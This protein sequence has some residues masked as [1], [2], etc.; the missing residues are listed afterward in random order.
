VADDR[1]ALG[2]RGEDMAVRHLVEAGYVILERNYRCSQGEMDV[3]AR[4]G[5]RLAFVEV[6]TRRGDSF[7]TAKD[8]VSRAKQRRLAAVARSYLQEHALVDVDWGIDVVAIQF[9]PGGS[10]RQLELVRNAVSESG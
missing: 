6:R 4:D 10:L 9:V 5:D 1:R 7:G 2:R 3:I 8:S